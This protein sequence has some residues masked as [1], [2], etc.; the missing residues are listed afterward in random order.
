MLVWLCHRTM[1]LFFI[2]LVSNLT[3]SSVVIL[4]MLV[5]STDCKICEHM[6]RVF[7]LVIIVTSEL[8]I[9]LSI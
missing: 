2:V 9:E 5:S 8:S 7:Y 1:F 3:F 6:D 4:L